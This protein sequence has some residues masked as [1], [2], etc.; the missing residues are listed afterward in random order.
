VAQ[1]EHTA[2]LIGAAGFARKN[3]IVLYLMTSAAMAGTSRRDFTTS[4]TMP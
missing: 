2:G 4:S 3:M 1:K